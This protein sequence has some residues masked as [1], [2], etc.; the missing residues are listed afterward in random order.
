[1]NFL[2]SSFY[3]PFQLCVSFVSGSEFC[4]V[5]ISNSN[6]RSI[7]FFYD[8]RCWA[9]FTKC[10]TW[11]KNLIEPVEVLFLLWLAW[12]FRAMFTWTLS[13]LRGIGLA[14]PSNHMNRDSSSSIFDCSFWAR[15][16]AAQIIS[17]FLC[18]K[19]MP[20]P[21][22]V[23]LSNMTCPELYLHRFLLVAGQLQGQDCWRGLFRWWFYV[24]HVESLYVTIVASCPSTLIGSFEK[25]FKSLFC[26]VV[27]RFA[28]GV[29]SC[30]L[31]SSVLLMRLTTLREWIIAFACTFPNCILA[32][33]GSSWFAESQEM[34]AT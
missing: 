9:D 3:V 22:I 31:F 8:T 12:I 29:V 26:F 30:I 33:K 6:F 10:A 2:R 21:P 16:F 28:D 23:L 19:T 14:M 1:M 20:C 5:G 13:L 4:N 24:C 18:Q 11:G 32:F 34:A 17:L 15:I 27:T 7:R 25:V